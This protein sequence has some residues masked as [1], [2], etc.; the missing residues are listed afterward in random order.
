MGDA[1]KP[2]VEVARN[3]RE[4]ETLFEA[5]LIQ[6]IHKAN[7]RL[8]PGGEAMV[9]LAPASSPDEWSELVAA[10]EFQHLASCPKLDHTRCRYVEHANDEDGTEPLLQTLLFWS[11]AWR[12]E[13]GYP[14]ESRPTV[15]SEVRFIR[16]AL[17][18]AWSTL[19]EWEDFAKDIK[20]A[21]TRM[22]NLLYAGERA[23][24][25]AP[26]MYEA[27]RGARLVRKVVPKRGSDGA[28]VWGLS[29]WHCP[30]CKRTWDESRYAAMVTAAHEAT[31]FEDIDGDVWCSMDYAA[32]QVDRPEATIRVWVHRS[33]HPEDRGH[34]IATACLV[35]GRRVRFVRLADVMERH[36]QAKK[37]K[38]A[39]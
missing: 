19:P 31:K 3:L 24:R 21:K 26:C 28:K 5:L 7:D 34:P 20:S 13:H 4:M 12:A 2:V 27:C 23:E 33:S 37:R 22:E 6:A 25:G 8:M 39:A 18:W 30:R 38:P 9:A 11:E 17:D 35:A 32:R 14:L 1:V 15:A 10:A 16:W 36:E 29:D